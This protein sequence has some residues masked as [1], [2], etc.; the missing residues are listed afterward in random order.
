MLTTLASLAL[1]AGGNELENL[2]LGILVNQTAPEQLPKYTA[3]YEKLFLDVLLPAVFGNSKS[4]SYAPSS[5]SNGWASLNFSNPIPIVERYFNL[6]PGSIYGETDFYNYNPVVLYNDSALPVGRFSNEFGYH[7]MPSVQSWRSQISERDLSFNSSTVFLRDHHFPPGSLNT[8][9]YDNSSIGQAQMTESVEMWYP[10]P[11]KTDSVANFSAWCHATQIFQ[12]D[13]YKFE[14]EFYR[15]GSGLPERQLGS[16]YWQLEDIWVA[17]TWAG[18]EYDGRWKVLH[19]TAK[20]IYEH[21]IISPHFDRA[22][23][24]LSAWVTSDLWESAKGKASFEWF[25]WSGKKL[26]IKTPSSVDFEVGAINSTR[27]LQTNTTEILSGH[28]LNNALLRLTVE[29]EGKLPN[30]KKTQKFTHENWF[31]PAALKEAKLVDPGLELSYSNSTKTFTVEGKK[32]VASW[33]WLDYPAGAVLNFESNAFWLVP[34]EKK[35]IGYTVKSDTT[36]GRWIDGVT[37]QS[38][39]NQT[40]KE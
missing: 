24:N 29:A 18:I 36:N 26:D 31:H 19:Y 6:T 25:D 37:V 17:P 13:L 3:E 32:G 5:T 4:I 8:S 2:E 34:G 12:A 35:E 22:T 7:S 39:W 23:G 40:Q 27:V 21:V 38:L 16:L 9:N 11:Y 20:D 30:S 15:R 33:V 1:W 14:I 10:T 28:D